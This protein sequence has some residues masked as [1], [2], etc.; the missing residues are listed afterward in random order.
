[1]SIRHPLTVATLLLLAKAGA[2]FAE[3]PDDPREPDEGDIPEP[4]VFDLEVAFR[5]ILGC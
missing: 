4:M 5:A 2:A 1:M 3:H